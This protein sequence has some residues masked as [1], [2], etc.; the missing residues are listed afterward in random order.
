MKVR[1][2]KAGDILKPEDLRIAG[3]FAQ[4]LGPPQSEEFLTQMNPPS[5]QRYLRMV[6]DQPELVNKVEPFPQRWRRDRKSLAHSLAPSEEIEL[7]KLANLPL[8]DL[9]F[10]LDQARNN[11]S[12]VALF[13]YHREHLLFAGDAQYGNWRWWLE[14]EQSGEILSQIR[15][16]QDCPP[17]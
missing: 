13:I 5:S 7:Q 1:Y 4:I 10:A 6:G 12:I 8:E 9:T 14:K 2:L 15:L 16:F 3:L 11:E 17:W